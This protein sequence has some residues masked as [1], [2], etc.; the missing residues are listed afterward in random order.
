MDIN[1]PKVCCQIFYKGS[2]ELEESLSSTLDLALF[3][4]GSSK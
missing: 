2:I 4:R 3:L 1:R